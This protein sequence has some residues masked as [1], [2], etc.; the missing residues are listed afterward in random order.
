MY[1]YI[2]FD[3][4]GT[5]TDPKEGI[6][7]C[8]RY[9][10]HSFGIEAE[11][12]DLVDFIGP[13]LAE[14]FRKYYQMSEE[15]ALR[16]VAKYRERFSGTGIYENGVYSGIAELLA[17]LQKSGRKV[18]L[19]TSKPEVYARQILD[20]YALSSYFDVIVGSEMNGKRTDKAEVIEEALRQLGIAGEEDKSRTLMVGDRLH[21]MVGASKNGIRGLGV[22]YGYAHEGELE[23]A[24]A[25]AVVKTVQELQDYLTTH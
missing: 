18:A 22:Y 12:D 15:D 17:G 8:V 23:T 9:A 19:A 14:S 3:L 1:Q 7:K 25:S 11:L 10:L 2:L 4:D 13:P 24:G 21:D 20:H 16:A 5:L 6:T